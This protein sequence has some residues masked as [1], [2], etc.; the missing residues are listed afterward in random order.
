MLVKK[1]VKSSGGDQRVTDRLI[2][3]KLSEMDALVMLVPNNKGA[4]LADWVEKI[5]GLKAS[6]SRRRRTPS[7]S[8]RRS[9]PPSSRRRSRPPSTRHRSR[10]P[11]TRRRSRPPSTRLHSI[12]PPRQRDRA[13]PRRPSRTPSRSQSRS[14]FERPLPPSSHPP[15]VFEAASKCNYCKEYGHWKSECKVLRNTKCYKCHC[16]GHLANMCNNK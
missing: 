1:L 5:E 13:S 11:S 6:A 3:K 16:F 8:L 14:S 10:P 7:P 15:I 4:L 12:T 9:S 2:S